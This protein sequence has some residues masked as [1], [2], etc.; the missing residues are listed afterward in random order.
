[1]TTT[2]RSSFF[3]LAF[4]CLAATANAAR[5]VVIDRGPL[6]EHERQAAISVTV[7]LALP[8]RAEA[9]QLQQKIYTPGAPEYHQFLTAQQFTARFALGDADVARVVAAFAKYG[10]AAERSTATTLK[11]TGKVADLERAFSTT[12][13]TYEVAGHDNQTGYSYR[14]A[15]VRPG[16]PTEMKRAVTAVFGLDNRPAAHTH[17]RTN[18]AAVAPSATGETTL[19]SGKSFGNL[20]VIDFANQY[21]V[22]PLYGAGVTGSGRTIGIMTLA[23][24]T[25]SDAFLY[26]SALGL[27]VNPN[28]ITIKNVDGGPGAPSDAS[29]SDETTIDVEQSGGL[30]PG[31]KI[32]VYQ[33]PN[34]NQGFL[35]VFAA[36]IEANVADSLSTSWG[37]SEIFDAITGPV[38]DP[39]TGATNA[40][41]ITAAHE[42]FLRAAIQGQTV[43]AASGDSGAYDVDEACTVPYNP[44][45]PNSCSA[46]I[47]VD[48][49]ASDTY[50]TAAGGTTLAGRQPYCLNQACT[51][52][53]YQIEIPQESVWGW[54]YLTGLCQTLGFDPISCGIF[55]AGGGGGVSVLFPAPPYQ[56]GVSGIQVSQPGQNFLWQIPG[57]GAYSYPLPASFAGRNVPDVSFNA[58]PDSGYVIVY[59]SDKNGL[60]ALSFWGGTSFVAPQL[61]GVSALLDQYVGKRIGFL[62]PIVYGLA[63]SGQA[64]GGS[65]APLNQIT[66]GDNWFYSGSK[67][68][69]LGAGL[70]TLDVA[71]LA[72][73][74]KSQP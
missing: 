18:P 51:P 12:L 37:F 35:D 19:R 47:S 9:E 36:A 5:P 20:T 70:G 57:F 39:T 64:Y 28:R 11:V 74:L 62:N 33:A 31:A 65:K 53:F 17:N 24:F 22:D 23:A 6:P 45:V 73:V 2:A 44:A 61:A 32:I 30:A 15:A 63:A 69:N 66:T 59:T 71:N 60:H 58:D 34:T 52:P 41:F 13:H 49:P 25:P 54:D 14:A 26:W 46:T 29:G 8:G 50:L 68:Y 43:F 48:Y 3:I 1:M 38:T 27:S 16:I 7:S 55:P 42:L 56:T 10:L 72:T 67:G 40:D 4:V 21:D